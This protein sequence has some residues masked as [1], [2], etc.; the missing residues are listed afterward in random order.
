[1]GSG[2]RGNP[3]CGEGGGGGVPSFL[4]FLLSDLELCPDPTHGLPDILHLLGRRQ[5]LQTR[6]RQQVVLGRQL[7]A[8]LRHHGVIKAVGEGNFFGKTVL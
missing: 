3:V 8:E 6:L 1:M 4:F 5:R 2:H 7:A